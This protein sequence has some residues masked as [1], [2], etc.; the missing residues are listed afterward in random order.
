MGRKIS[1]FTRPIIN[2]KYTKCIL[3]I[4]NNHEKTFDELDLFNTFYNKGR[5]IT[6]LTIFNFT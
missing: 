5:I 2:D 6:K 1:I 4:E 3:F